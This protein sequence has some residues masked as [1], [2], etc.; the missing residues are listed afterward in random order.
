MRLDTVAIR[1]Q[2][3]GNSESEG[4]MRIGSAL[5]VAAA[6]L[7][8][9]AGAASAQ[10]LE[11]KPAMSGTATA[12]PTQEVGEAAAIAVWTAKV[13]AEY[14]PVF[15]NWSNARSTTVWCER[16]TSAIGFNLWRCTAQALPCRIP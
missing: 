2:P 15:A 16:Y 14:F 3:Y 10:Q 13:T 8:A 5:L 6:T 9:G 4:F 1:Y 7:C 12:Q 11:C